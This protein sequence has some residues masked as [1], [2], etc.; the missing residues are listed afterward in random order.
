[1]ISE[2]VLRPAQ[3]KMLDILQA[4]DK[5]CF[6]HD[7]KYFL[8]C[9]TLLGAVRHKGFIPWDD[10]C[11]I[12]MMRSDYEKFMQVA[13]GE[14]PDHLFLQTHELDSNYP[15]KICKIR[16]KNTKLVE[17]D[18]TEHEKYCQGIFVDIFIYDYYPEWGRYVNKMLEIGPHLRMKRKAYS[19]GSLMRAV[20]GLLTSIPYVLHVAL[21]ALYLSIGKTF[22]KNQKMPLIGSEIILSE[23]KLF[24]KEVIF[25]LKRERIFEGQEF[26]LPHDPDGYLK[27]YYGN[28][29]QVP[30]P[31]KREIHAK[32]IEI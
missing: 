8:A 31:E 18:E 19:K 6:K 10:D 2:E 5:I 21:R 25:P 30:P 7:I 12:A 16:N 17:C 26:Y 22:R 32:K 29:M 15:K 11:D 9:G 1:M 23:E 3:L 24:P 20:V 4:I 13:P 28:Y 14:L 27:I